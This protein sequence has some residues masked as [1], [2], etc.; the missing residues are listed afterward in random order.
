M[1]GVVEPFSML[2]PL[3]SPSTLPKLP[4]EPNALM[5]GRVTS[6]VKGELFA[7]I[8]HGFSYENAR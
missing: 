5:G 4:S 6:L 2:I 8:Q 7:I 1:D 3:C